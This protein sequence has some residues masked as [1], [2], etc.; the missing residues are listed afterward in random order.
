MEIAKKISTNTDKDGKITWSKSVEEKDITQSIRV[1][2]VE[3]G[4]VVRVSEDGYKGTGDKREWYNDSK[5]YISTVNPLDEGEEAN[6]GK[7]S[8]KEELMET[9]A[10]LKI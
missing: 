5:T 10:N 8:Y 2:E 6:E 9:L 3:N 7:K 1:E 4:F